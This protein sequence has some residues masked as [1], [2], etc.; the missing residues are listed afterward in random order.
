[1][2]TTTPDKHSGANIPGSTMKVTKPSAVK[3]GSL[4]VAAPAAPK[5]A[6]K[7]EWAEEWWEQPWSCKDE[8][9]QDR[10]WDSGK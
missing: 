1:M 2:A 10:P 4:C 7:Q 5:L 9:E 8:L 6:V 3:S